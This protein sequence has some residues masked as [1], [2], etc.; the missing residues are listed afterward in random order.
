MFHIPLPRGPPLPQ[1]RHWSFPALPAS[2]WSIR[3]PCRPPWC[4]SRALIEAFAKMRSS[5]AVLRALSQLRAGR[6]PR[7]P[8]C[9]RQLPQ[10]PAGEAGVSLSEISCP[11]GGGGGAPA[12]RARGAAGV[13]WEAAVYCGA[14]AGPRGQQ[15]RAGGTAAG[16]AFTT[17]PSP[18]G[19]P[20]GAASRPQQQRDRAGHSP[21]RRSQQRSRRWG[22]GR[23]PPALT[24]PMVRN[25]PRAASPARQ[26]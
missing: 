21:R 24:A 5:E 23:A 12:P 16:G 2:C 9:P 10:H 26:P 13:S 18:S 20:P 14:P 22:R 1:T 15:R 11:P 6:S 25:R 17:P 3:R 19:W 4:R 8:A 7:S